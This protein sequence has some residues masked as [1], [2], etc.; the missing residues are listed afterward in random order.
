MK[1]ATL[2][3]NVRLR[4][5]PAGTKLPIQVD[6]EGTPTDRYWRR[7]LKDARRDNCVTLEKAAKSESKS[8]KSKKVTDHAGA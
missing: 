7:R 2:I 6:A 3:L 5:H 4:G 8:S 1:T